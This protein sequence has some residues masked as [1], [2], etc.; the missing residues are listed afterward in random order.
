MGGV[1]YG[2]Q[3]ILARTSSSIWPTVRY[4]DEVKLH[5][6]KEIRSGLDCATNENSYKQSLMC[7]Q[8]CVDI[9]PVQSLKL[10]HALSHP[11]EN[12]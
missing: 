6:R 3:A 1:L 10:C 11:S 9:V 2:E 7:R 4:G 8:E 5:S 12:I